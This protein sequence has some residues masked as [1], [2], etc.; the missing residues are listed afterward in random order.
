MLKKLKIINKGDEGNW[1]IVSFLCSI[2]LPIFVDAKLEFTKQLCSYFTPQI[3]DGIKSIFESAKDISDKDIVTN[4][5]VALIAEKGNQTG[6]KKRYIWIK[7]VGANK[8]ENW[9][10]AKTVKKNE[11]NDICIIRHQPIEQMSFKMKP[12]KKLK[13]CWGLLFS[14]IS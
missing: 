4:C 9:A 13:D 14:K 5:H 11:K 1:S 3:Y 7:N 8:D 12:I 6:N 10:L 2:E